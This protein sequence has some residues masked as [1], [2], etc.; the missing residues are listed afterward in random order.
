MALVTE[1][2][3]ARGKDAEVYDLCPFCTRARMIFGL[4]KIPHRL[5]FMSYDDVETPTASRAV[6][7]RR[8]ALSTTFLELRCFH[9]CTMPAYG[10]VY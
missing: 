2:C 5:I 1:K 7:A 10:R 4:K 8:S 3:V 9:I 6:D